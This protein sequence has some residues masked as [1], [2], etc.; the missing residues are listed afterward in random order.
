MR[1]KCGAGLAITTAWA[2]MDQVVRALRGT[3]AG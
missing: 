2:A 1:S 3:A